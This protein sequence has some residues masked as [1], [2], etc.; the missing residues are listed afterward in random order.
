M[1]IFS[2]PTDFDYSEYISKVESQIQGNYFVSASNLSDQLFSHFEN[3][4]GSAFGDVLPWSSTQDQIRFKKGE[5]SLWAGYN[6][7]R[8]SMFTGMVALWLA[9]T[10]KCCVASLELPILDTLQRMTQQAAGCW[11]SPAFAKSLMQ[12]LDNNLWMYDELASITPNRLL[13]LIYYAANDLGCEHIFIDSLTKCGIRTDDLAGQKELADKIVGAAKALGVHVHLVAHLRKPN[14][15]AGLADAKPS[16][17]DIRG[18]SELSD[19][20]HNV[21]IVFANRRKRLAQ[22]KVKSG[23]TLSEAEATFLDKPDMELLV[24]KQRNMPFEGEINF[25]F[26]EKSLQFCADSRAENLPFEVN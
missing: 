9:K 22:E 19:L 12:K 2:I 13:G 7:H 17:Y 24:A 14:N 10:K 16:K 18:A 23:A 15:G 4:H 3:R 20:A 6:G 21:Y 8:K 1:T 26:N 5:V 11:P 25:W